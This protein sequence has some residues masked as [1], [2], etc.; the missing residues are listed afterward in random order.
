MP[1]PSLLD[2]VRAAVR[3]RH[4]SIRTEEAYV[5]VIRRF[6]LYHNKRHPKQMGVDEIRQY[7]SHLATDGHVATSTQNVALAAPQFILTFNARLCTLMQN[8]YMRA[9]HGIHANKLTSRHA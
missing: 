7:L 3:L 1:Q 9:A 4:Y 5:N 2:Q 8:L 6:I